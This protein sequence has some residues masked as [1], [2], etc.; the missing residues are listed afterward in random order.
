VA[1]N[2]RVLTPQTGLGDYVE[3]IAQLRIRVFRDWPYLYDGDID[4]ERRYL[5]EFAAAPGAVCVAAFDGADMIGASTG[6]PMAGEHE[7]IKA[8]F[9]EASIPV[10]TIFYCAESVLL[11]EYRGRG[12][13]RQFFDGREAHARALGGFDTLAFCGVVRPDDHPLKPADA[14]PLDAVWRHFGYEADENL[15]CHFSWK[16]VDRDEMTEKPLKFWLKSL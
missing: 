11:P 16:D 1:L 3:G 12:L 9:L 5:A 15:I 6:M 7:P 2:V 14:Q 8:P 10:D 4:Y 13:Y